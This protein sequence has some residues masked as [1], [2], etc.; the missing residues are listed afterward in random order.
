[1]IEI[2]DVSMSYGDN[3]VLKN[4]SL[5]VKPK[6]IHG[7]LGPN[8]AGKST[9]IKLLLGLLKPNSG[10][11]KING[12]NPY[13]KPIEARRLIGFVPEELTIYEH[14]TP[15]EFLHVIGEI[16]A[17]SRHEVQKRIDDLLDL[18]ELGHVMHQKMSSFS[19]GMKQKIMISSSVLHSPE[20]LLLD[21]PLSGMDV[22]A[23]L[24]FRDLIKDF[25]NQGKTIVYSS[26][27][28]E[29]VERVCDKV[30]IL[31]DGEIKHNLD[32]KEIRKSPGKLEKLFRKEAQEKSYFDLSQEII[33]R[34]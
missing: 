30:T 1:M 23:V 10:E 13:E 3:D 6:M 16:H 33:E 12:V 22:N 5:E 21:E 7:Y 31:I 25:S 29:V 18:F 24:V 9:T 17:M 27:I 14:L 8:G 11:I 15:H 34:L 32:K 19:R 26:H 4:I 2:K 20:I 28:V